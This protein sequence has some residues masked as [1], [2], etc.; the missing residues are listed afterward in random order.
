MP[1][2]KEYDD[3]GIP[4]KSTSAKKVEYDDFGIPVKK[5]RRNFTR[6][7]RDSCRSFIREWRR[8]SI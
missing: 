8:S 5:K 7:L 6:R 2:N 1:D 3:F 4:I